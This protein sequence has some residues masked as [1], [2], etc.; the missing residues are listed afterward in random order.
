MDASSQH[1]HERWM[2]LAI[3]NASLAEGL[4]AENPPVGCVLTDAQG[5]LCK[6]WPYPAGRQAMPNRR[7]LITQHTQIVRHGFQVVRHML[8]LSHARIQ[9]KQSPV[10]RRLNQL[11]S[12]RYFML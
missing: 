10:L 7:Q 4:V 1:L 3:R 6:H 2:R 12:R 11:V 5:R 8:R 9:A